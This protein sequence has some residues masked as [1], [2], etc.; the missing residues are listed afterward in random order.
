MIVVKIEHTSSRI[1]LCYMGEFFSGL[2]LTLPPAQPGTPAC[3]PSA[4][5]LPY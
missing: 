5:P 1:P 4:R 2:I 3:I